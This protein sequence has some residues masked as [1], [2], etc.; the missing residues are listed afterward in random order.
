MNQEIAECLGSASHQAPLTRKQAR[1]L[2]G[3]YSLPAVGYETVVAIKPDGMGF[4]RR[5][6]VANVSGDFYAVSYDTPRSEWAAEFRVQ[7]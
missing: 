1:A 4:K 2:C 5:L 7:I 3:M 6:Q